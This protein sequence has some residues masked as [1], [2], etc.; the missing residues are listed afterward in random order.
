MSKNALELSKRRKHVLPDKMKAL[1]AKA[2]AQKIGYLRIDDLPGTNIFD[3]LPSLSFNPNRHIK[4]K[5]NLYLVKSGSVIIRHIHH[6]YLVKELSPG[7]LFGNMPLLGQT[8]I[9]TAAIAG[10][11]G[12]RLAVLDTNTAKQWI[13]SNPIALLEKLGPRLALAETGHYRSR[14][15]L[16]DSRL[17]ALLL[18]LSAEGSTVEGFSHRQT[19][20]RNHR[21]GLFAWTKR[22]SRRATKGQRK[23]Q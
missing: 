6:E 23:D 17:A 21:K 16:A 15:Q 19:V 18:E 9:V 3:S 5:G 20:G 14:F 11:E 13:E 2:L 1:S 7:V 8:M 12:T 4:S 22:K 10:G